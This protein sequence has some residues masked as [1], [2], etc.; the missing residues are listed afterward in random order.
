MKKL[1]HIYNENF[2]ITH[3]QFFIEGEQPSNAVYV[4]NMSF[5]K[6]L[7]NPETLEVYEGA[8]PEE[9]AEQRIKQCKDFEKQMYIKRTNDGINT[10]AEIS[11]EFRLAK[12]SGTITE[13]AHAHIERTLIPVRNEVLA[14]Q[15]ISGLKELELIGS[16]VIGKQLYDRLYTQISNY[17]AENYNDVLE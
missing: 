9:I 8:T 4:E 16:E 11:A 13:E 7:V 17:I 1:Y 14:G 12:L 3:A 2:E 5:S 6:P 15:W 10:Y